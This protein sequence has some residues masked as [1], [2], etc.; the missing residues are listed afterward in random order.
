M[1]HRIGFVIASLLVA[2]MGCSKDNDIDASQTTIVYCQGPVQ[3]NATC[4]A[5]SQVPAGALC[6]YGSCRAPCTS[7]AECEALVP[8]SVCLPGASGSGCRFPE[9]AKCHDATGCK[10]GLVCAAGECRAPCPDGHCWLQGLSC[11]SG[12]CTGTAVGSAPEPQPEAGTDGSAG[13]AGDGGADGAAGSGV[14]P[15]W[16]T[17]TIP[18]SCP[19]ATGGPALVPVRGGYCI[20]ATEVTREQYAQWLSTVPTTDGQDA[21]CVWNKDFTPVF[22]WPPE[23]K[24]S[25]AVVGVDW[26]DAY[27]YCKAVGKRLCG[28]IGGG[29]TADAE[30]AD[31]AKSQWFN[32]CSSGGE[33]NYPYGGLP[34]AGAQAGYDEQACNG[35]DK[36][37][38]TTL[39]AGTCTGCV[40]SETGYAGVWDLSGSVEEWEDSCVGAAG[41]TDPCRKRGGSFI[42]GGADPLR[43]ANTAAVSRDSVSGNVGFRCCAP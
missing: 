25:H 6:V 20:D 4:E 9:E 39:P 31:A 37:V 16:G 41:K 18:S 8:G 33:F 29:A 5:T 17:E 42:T 32:A 36:G 19:Q 21:W 12:A 43:C 13:A 26:C 28:G 30:L 15:V 38:N 14:E 35:A 11:V 10:G 23:D 2:T 3:D 7:D 22:K 1:E 34:G 24:G 40:S 27:A